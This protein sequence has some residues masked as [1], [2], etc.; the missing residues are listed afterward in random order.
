MAA[1]PGPFG[2]AAE[3]AED[4]AVHGGRAAGIA[5]PKAELETQTAVDTEVQDR[6]LIIRAMDCV[7]GVVVTG[8]DR[9]E[10][11]AQVFGMKLQGFGGGG[12]G[13]AN[14]VM[15]VETQFLGSMKR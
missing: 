4:G 6:A 3:G 15:K 1:S 2:G 14:D 12:G 7:R 8:G 10:G 5:E 9:G 11:Q 13:D